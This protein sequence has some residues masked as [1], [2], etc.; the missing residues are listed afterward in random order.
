MYTQEEFVSDVFR[1]AQERGYRIETCRGKGYPQIDFGIKKLHAEH[2]KKLYP[3]VLEENANIGKLIDN[4]A[5]GRPCAHAPFGRIV[6]QIRKER[7]LWPKKFTSCWRPPTKSQTC[8]RLAERRIPQGPG[9]LP[10]NSSSIA[11]CFF[12]KELC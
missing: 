11:R 6:E 4:V 9:P 1:I 8:T 10:R 3:N 5:P 12:Q 2:I 7:A